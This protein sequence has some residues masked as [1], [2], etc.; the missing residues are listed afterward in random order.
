MSVDVPRKG[1]GTLS[2]DWLLRD[3]LREVKSHDGSGRGQSSTRVLPQGVGLR[4]VRLTE[5]Q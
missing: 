2:I 4:L 1:E 3:T 5:I